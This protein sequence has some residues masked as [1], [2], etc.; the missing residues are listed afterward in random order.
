MDTGKWKVNKKTISAMFYLLLSL[1]FF[2]VLLFTRSRSGF[3]GLALA[4]LAFWII[5]FR[6]VKGNKNLRLPFAFFHVACALIVF[7]N[8]SSIDQLDRWVTLKGWT[9][10]ITRREMPAPNVSAPSGTALEFGGTESGTIR[11]YVWLGAVN[12][13][14]ANIKNLAIGTGTETFAF[15]FYQ[16]RP[17]GIILPVSGISSTKHNV[18]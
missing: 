1:L 5:L 18:I 11:K 3:V 10:R 7:F 4:D 8:G 6:F 13:W 9:D 2:V 14:R 17:P 15:A 12:A 16:C